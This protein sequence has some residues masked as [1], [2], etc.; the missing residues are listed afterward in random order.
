MNGSDVSNGVIQI[1]SVDLMTWGHVCGDHWGLPEANMLCRQLGF[2]GANA[3][4]TQSDVAGV[5][6]IQNVTCTGSEM[7]ASECSYNNI[8]QSCPERK[9]AGV[10]CKTGNVAE[11]FFNKLRKFSDFSL[12]CL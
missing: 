3:A 10:V 6:L 5:F 7:D 1:Y 9:A 11:L 4:F 2:A 12:N 8:S